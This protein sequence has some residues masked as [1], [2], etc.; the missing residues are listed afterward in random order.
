MKAGDKVTALFLWEKNRISIPALC[1]DVRLLPPCR[2]RTIVWWGGCHHYHGVLV[3]SDHLNRWHSPRDRQS[4]ILSQSFSSGTFTLLLV[5]ST[6]QP[7]H[8]KQA[9]AVSINL[10]FAGG[11]C[12]GTNRIKSFRSFIH[13]VDLPIVLPRSL[14][15]GR[16]AVA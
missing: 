13:V 1:R 16:N 7:L 4:S 8:S 9:A 3:W 15:P 6:N 14:P 5:L 10:S 2:T 12:L 11:R